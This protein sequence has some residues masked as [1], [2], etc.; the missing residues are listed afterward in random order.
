MI[1]FRSRTLVRDLNVVSS[2]ARNR[3]N[4]RVSSVARNRRNRRVSS[5]ARNRRSEATTSLNVVSNA[6]SR[7]NRGFS[8]RSKPEERDDYARSPTNLGAKRPN[9]FEFTFLS[10]LGFVHTPPA[11][12]D[13]AC[14]TA[15]TVPP[16][17]PSPGRSR[18]EPFP[19]P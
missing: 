1:Q 11:I 13:P 14:P 8:L 16:R 4:L 5:V 7:Y 19:G 12:T 9:C 15:E 3:R 10:F 2:V 18:P 17:T 6:S